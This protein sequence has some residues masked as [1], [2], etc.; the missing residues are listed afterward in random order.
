M[1]AI[2]S[3]VNQGLGLATAV[4]TQTPGYKAAVEKNLTKQAIAK[5][6]A[7]VQ[8]KANIA[9][10]ALKDIDLT[11]DGPDKDTKI[12]QAIAIS[13]DK[14][15]AA[16]KAFNLDPTKERYDKLI[17]V[18]TKLNDIHKTKEALDKAKKERE[19]RAEV[20]ANIEDRMDSLQKEIDDFTVKAKAGSLTEDEKI[21]IME[22][23]PEIM[24][25]KKEIRNG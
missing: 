18:R 15:D 11:K 9:S 4:T 19:N 7:N 1:G 10:K 5:E 23:G 22:I 8:A 25:F 6:L 3:A 13:E 14:V 12:D 17:S 16:E 2:Q 21:R 24:K 20:K